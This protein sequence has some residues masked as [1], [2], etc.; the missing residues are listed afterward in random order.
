MT[1]P[2]DETPAGTIDFAALD[3]VLELQADVMAGGPGL[4]QDPG[5]CGVR[6]R[7]AR[8]RAACRSSST[9]MRSTP[10]RR[11]RAARG[12][13]RRRRRHHAASRRDGAAAERHRRGRAARSTGRMRA[14]S[15]PRTGSTSCSRDTGRSSPA[16]DGRSFVNLTGNPGM[17]TGG[18]GDRAHRH[19]CRLVR[20][21][22]RRRSRRKLS[23][24]LHGAAGDL[25]EADDGPT[26]LIASDVAARLGDAMLELSGRARRENPD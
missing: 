15:Q 25:A 23:V 9:R 12:P 1:L 21:A 18:T 6:A 14:S 11:T 22:A 10:S 8:A 4:G 2:L 24:Y 5:T 16:P 3:R 13:G 7:L 17:A 20:A 26:A 19:D